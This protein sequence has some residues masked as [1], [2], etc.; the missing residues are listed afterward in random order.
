MISEESA[1]RRRRTAVT[2]RSKV[3]LRRKLLVL[4]WFGVHGIERFQ[5]F[6]VP[7]IFR[8]LVELPRKVAG[9]LVLVEDDRRGFQ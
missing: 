8:L 2:S 9:A 4:D 7:C 1:I 6:D 3:E 5:P